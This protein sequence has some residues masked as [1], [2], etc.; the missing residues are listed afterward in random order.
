MSVS[1]DTN[2]C[3][4]MIRR[5]PRSTRTDTLFPYTTLFRSILA[6]LNDLLSAVIEQGT[7]RAARIGRP[8][9][10]KTG[11]TSDYH[12]AWFV[13]YTPDLIATVW[14]G[15]DD[16]SPMKK[17]TGSGLPAQIWRGFMS[18]A[19]KGRPVKALPEPPPRTITL[20]SLWD[21]IVRQFSSPGSSA[22][23][24]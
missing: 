13:G 4:L 8:A 6:D 17:V 21:R 15:N 5:P 10:G 22:S 19:L 2:F 12:D 1:T 20:P 3:F 16:N 14:V 18:D 9:A 11:T 24:A 7:G 23:A